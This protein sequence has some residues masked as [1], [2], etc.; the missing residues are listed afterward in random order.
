MMTLHKTS[1]IDSFDEK[2]L[3]SLRLDARKTS[4]ELADASAGSETWNSVESFEGIAP[5]SPRG[6]W[7]IV[8][9]LCR[10]GVGAS[11]AQRRSSL[12]KG[13]HPA[14]R[15]PRS[16]PYC[17]GLRVSAARRRRRSGEL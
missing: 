6:S 14:P 9:G 13:G 1:E 3:Q 12:P 7:S 10:R 15:Y 2:I 16:A 17:G 4:V 5:T 8:R 11:R